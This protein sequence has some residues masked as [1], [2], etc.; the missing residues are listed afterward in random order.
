MILNMSQA[1]KEGR[2]ACLAGLP[3]NMNPYQGKKGVIANLKRAAWQREFLET[4]KSS[5]GV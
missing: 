1:K 5:K 4:E 3:M 2:E